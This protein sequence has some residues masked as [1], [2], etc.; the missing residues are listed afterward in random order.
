MPET[1]A[2]ETA[3][4]KRKKPVVP[5]VV[6]VVATALVALL[7]YGVVHG[8]QNT[9]LDDAVKQGKHPSAPG[10]NMERPVLNGAGQ[11]SL[12][13]YRGQVVVLNFWASWCEPCRGEAPIM[14]K[15]QRSLTST[16]A[17]T[18]LGATYNDA[19]EDSAKF[20]REFKVAYPS[21][22]DV[23]TELAQKYGT[24][25]LPETFVI[26]KNGKIV[27]ISRGAV[28]QSWLDGAIAEAEKA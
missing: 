19:P 20:E 24:R 9:T 17:G 8:G 7:V 15:A 13:D 25:A 21:L 26:D 5:I 11:K 23:G 28:K 18:V 27:A 10:Y 16:H 2:P 14:E 12:A 4:E 22:R 1:A 3:S 6:V